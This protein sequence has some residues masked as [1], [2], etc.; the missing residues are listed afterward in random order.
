[1]EVAKRG[2]QFFRQNNFQQAMRRFNEAWLLDHNSGAALWGMA[3]IDSNK[4]GS[5]GVL[6][7]FAEAEPLV[8]NNLDFAVD[9]DFIAALQGKMLRP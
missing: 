3:A 5:P 8:G 9:P 1:M 7:L 6:Q 2:W 4:P